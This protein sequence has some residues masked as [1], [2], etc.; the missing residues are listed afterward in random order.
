[1]QTKSKL[2][3]ASTSRLDGRDIGGAESKQL[4][5]FEFAQP[6]WNRFY[7]QESKPLILHDSPPSIVF[8]SMASKNRL[9]KRGKL[10]SYTNQTLTELLVRKSLI[11]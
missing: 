5:D 10:N 6:R 8:L 9:G 3:V 1:M 11:L 7:T 4:V 2:H